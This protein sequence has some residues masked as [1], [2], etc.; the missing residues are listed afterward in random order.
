[1][2]PL[3]L[4]NEKKY[5]PT[6]ALNDD[7]KFLIYHNLYYH[8]LWQRHGE[9][10]RTP[11]PPTQLVKIEGL[12]GVG[13]S[14]VIMCLRN[15]A[16]RIKNSNLADLTSA[17]TGAA[18]FLISAPTH[19]RLYSLPTGKKD[20]K[21][22]PKNLGVTDALRVLEMHMRASEA[23][24]VLMDE[25]SMVSCE[26]LVHLEHRHAE[27]RRGAPASVRRARPPGDDHY[28]I[29]PLQQVPADIAARPWGGFRFVYKIGD[30][31]QLPPVLSTPV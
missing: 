2:G 6:K 13:K 12:P 28:D 4:F 5:N 10:R 21:D 3:K 18:S 9:D 24:V 11:P 16:R 23:D 25:D 7:Q 31:N 19:Y 1:M 14:F 17:P 29:R 27:L 30:V 26:L 22:A 15:I 8:Y 20:F